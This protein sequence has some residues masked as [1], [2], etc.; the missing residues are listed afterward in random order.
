MST[1]DELGVLALPHRFRRISDILNA[2]I[3]QMYRDA[4]LDF[5]SAWFPMIFLLIDKGAMSVTEL[6]REMGQTHSAVSQLA[7][8]LIGK[9][10][11]QRHDDESDLRRRELALSEAGIELVLKTKPLW[12]R[13]V[14]ELDK[15]A[16]AAGDDFIDELSR[17]ETA[18]DAVELGENN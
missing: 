2:K 1:L 11:L 12:D 18:L 5:Q 8:K 9:G 13:L 14:D 15:L 3:D 10:Y 6:A 17:C 16:K 4:G 7:K